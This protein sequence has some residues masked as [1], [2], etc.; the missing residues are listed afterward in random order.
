MSTLNKC[1]TRSCRD[2]RTWNGIAELLAQYDRKCAINACTLIPNGNV[3]MMVMGLDPRK[4]TA[5]ELK[6][7]RRIVREGMEQGAVRVSSGLDYIPSLYADEYEL[8]ELCREI[9]PF[10]GVYVTHMRGYKPDKEMQVK[11]TNGSTHTIY[12]WTIPLKKE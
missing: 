5:D 12:L 2:G 11:T 9:A 6:Q 3:R 1:S 4:A 7:M 10:N 8:T